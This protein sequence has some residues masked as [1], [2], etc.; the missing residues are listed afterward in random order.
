MTHP[1]SIPL[2]TEMLPAPAALAPRSNQYQGGKERPFG[3]GGAVRGMRNS[4]S[5][6][7]APA[8]GAINATV[9]LRQ[10]RLPSGE[11]GSLCPM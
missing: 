9:M 2:L 1:A 3:T 10:T 7:S 8:A 5:L 4:S 6:P 11:P